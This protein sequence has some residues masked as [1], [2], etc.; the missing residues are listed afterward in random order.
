MK[1]SSL[2]VIDGQ[3]I[4]P[5]EK[6]AEIAIRG[7]KTE[8]NPTGLRPATNK[9]SVVMG[10]HGSV[11]GDDQGK[12]AR[13]QSE[14]GERSSILRG[15]NP[16]FADIKGGRPQ[17]G[18]KS[19]GFSKPEIQMGTLCVSDSSHFWGRR[20]LRTTPWLWKK[21]RLHCHADHLFGRAGRFFRV[22]GLEQRQQEGES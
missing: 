15:P 8:T 21:A 7:A 13:G 4:H 12:L 9:N 19:S 5:G 10:N 2:G 16:K 6:T 1:N 11:E 22:I 18:R 17:V 20:R 14:G 3:Q